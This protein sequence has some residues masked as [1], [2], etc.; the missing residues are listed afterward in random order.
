MWVMKGTNQ[1]TRCRWE[2]GG[3]EGTG[4]Y[5]RGEDVADKG[6]ITLVDPV[7]Q[8]DIETH[9]L[10]GAATPNVRA[11]GVQTSS[12][13]FA[14]CRGSQTCGGSLVRVARRKGSQGSFW[15]RA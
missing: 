9:S 4:R 7:Q 8:G 13:C 5:D 10:Y 6:A 12:V 14:P 2:F 3:G 15:S 1:S 11:C